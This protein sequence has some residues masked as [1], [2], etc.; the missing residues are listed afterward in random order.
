MKKHILPIILIVFS[1]AAFG[2]LN[3]QLLS[4]DWSFELDPLKIGEDEK[5]MYYL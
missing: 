2:Q 3:I 5:N 4:G 1:L